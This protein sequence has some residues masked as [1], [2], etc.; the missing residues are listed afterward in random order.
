[1]R[2][3][4]CLVVFIF[5]NVLAP[6]SPGA[7]KQLAKS[8]QILSAKTFYFDNQTGADAVG[9][10]AL[11]QLKKWRRFQVVRDKQS[12]DLI[13]LLSADPYHGGY[14][15]FASGQ[16]GTV[17]ADGQI[18]QDLVPNYNRLAP[19]RD[20]Y[21]TVIDPST[22]N[23]LW[24]DSHVWGGLLTGKNSVG[25]RLVQNCKSNSVNKTPVEP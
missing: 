3:Y 21:L 12:A 15:I 25:A 20:A 4:A 22:G 24:T 1:V 5:T 19:V 11:A 17:D 13:L 8:P 23:N 7:Q 18:Q 16:T 6:I 2:N 9:T 10:A 14:I